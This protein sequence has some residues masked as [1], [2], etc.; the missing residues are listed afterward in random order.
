MATTSVIEGD[1]VDARTMPALPRVSWGAIIGGVFSAMGIWALLYTFGLALGLSALDPSNPSSLKGSGMFAG[2]WGV[3]APLVAL[4]VGGLVAGRLSGVFSRGNGAVHGLI[5][6]GLAIVAGAYLVVTTVSSVIGGVGSMAA[7]AG[8]AA[9]KELLGMATG[10]GTSGMD[11]DDVLKPVNERLRA[12]GKPALTSSQLQA[13]AK[14]ALQQGMATGKLDRPA[15][16]RSLAQNTDLSR[17]DVQDLANRLQAQFDAAKGK[18]QA[19][20]DSAK[21]GALQAADKTGKAFWGVFGALAL[22]LASAVAGGAA[23]VAKPATARRRA[24]AIDDTYTEPPPPRSVPPRD[25]RPHH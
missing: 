17:A 15:L 1:F 16:E 4:F 9:G 8:G 23:G 7:Q 18:V 22:G 6:W 10:G 3:V 20:L 19:Q 14:D 24:R 5:M 2:I 12:E 21:T 13:T 25:I 11:L